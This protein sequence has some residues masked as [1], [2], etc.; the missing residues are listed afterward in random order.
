VFAETL[1]FRPALPRQANQVFSAQH[2]LQSPPVQILPTLT[3]MWHNVYVT[4]TKIRSTLAYTFVH[5]HATGDPTM[6]SHIREQ[7]L[8]YLTDEDTGRNES[9]DKRSGDPCTERPH[10]TKYK[11]ICDRLLRRFGHGEEPRI[12]KAFFARLQREAIAF[13]P[14]VYEAIAEVVDHVETMASTDPATDRGKLFCRSIKLR[15]EQAGY[16]GQAKDF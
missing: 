6:A 16:L 3:Q 2:S 13:G 11:T 9:S 15:L 14:D 7:L 10:K 1:R 12:R 5:R 4:Q 8:P